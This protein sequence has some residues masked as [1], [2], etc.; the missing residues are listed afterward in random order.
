[1]PGP[2][3]KSST[4]AVDLAATTECAATEAPG[5]APAK[6]PGSG[7]PSARRRGGMAKLTPTLRALALASRAADSLAPGLTARYAVR[8]FVMTSPA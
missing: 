8:H 3:T 4:A 2:E 6:R 5:W 1:M 7:A